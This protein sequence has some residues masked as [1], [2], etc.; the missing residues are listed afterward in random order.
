[1]DRERASGRGKR[2]KADALDFPFDGSKSK[3]TVRG[4]HAFS[5]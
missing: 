5:L 1:M 2:D 3:G 4:A